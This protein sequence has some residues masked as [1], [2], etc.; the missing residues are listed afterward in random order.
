MFFRSVEVQFADFDLDFEVCCLRRMTRA[1]VH[2]S[3]SESK[4]GARNYGHP[5]AFAKL[6]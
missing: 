2:L 5:F 1:G 3:G 6:G 4:K